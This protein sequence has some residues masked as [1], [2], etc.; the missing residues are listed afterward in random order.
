MVWPSGMGAGVLWSLTSF[1]ARE[2]LL[3]VE[4]LAEGERFR[5]SVARKN[6][7]EERRPWA[8]DLGHM[9]VT[10][11]WIVF[12][13]VCSPISLESVKDITWT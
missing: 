2:S 9:E 6:P 3:P 11:A 8:W 1:C 7:P 4:G 5:K 10:V 12:K 13:D